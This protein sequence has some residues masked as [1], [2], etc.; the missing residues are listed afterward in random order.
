[1]SLCLHKQSLDTGGFNLKKTQGGYFFSTEI[2]AITELVTNDTDILFR[3]R[4]I[5]Y[6]ENENTDE[7]SI[8]SVGIEKLT[9]SSSQ[10]SIAHGL[11]I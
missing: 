6:K 7:Q 11:N 3:G 4:E 10:I 5:G 8:S 1:M 9:F 2:L